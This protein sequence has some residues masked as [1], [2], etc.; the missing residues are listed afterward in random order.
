MWWGVS[1]ASAARLQNAFLSP[2]GDSPTGKPASAHL[3]RNQF[4]EACRREGL[5]EHSDKECQMLARCGSKAFV[6]RKAGLGLRPPSPS[7]A[8]GCN[9]SARSRSPRRS[10]G[11][12]LLMCRQC[13]QTVALAPAHK[14]RSGCV[15]HKETDPTAGMR[16]F[17]G[18][19]QNHPRSIPCRGFDTNYLHGSLR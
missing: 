13:S 6:E 9:K 11:H 2:C 17:S 16:A 1:P 8:V 12:G 15:A 19:A 4:G 18:A 10:V 14:G 3:S 5:T 7:S